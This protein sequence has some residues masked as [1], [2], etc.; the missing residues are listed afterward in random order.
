MNRIVSSAAL[1]ALLGFAAHAEATVPEPSASQS[2]LLLGAYASAPVD[3]PVVQAA[4]DFAQSRIPSVTLVE[5]NV[6]YTQ[7][8]KGLNI[9]LVATGVEE[10]RQVSWKFVVYK[11]LDGQMSLMIAERL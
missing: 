11:G 3:S 9:K 6:A 10:G 5:V 1:F 8:V 4:K 2:D 7:V